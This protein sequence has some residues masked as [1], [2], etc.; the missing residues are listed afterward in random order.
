MNSYL[1]L[2]TNI[3]GTVRDVIDNKTIAISLVYI[4]LG[5][6]GSALSGLR[7]SG[8][9]NSISVWLVLLLAIVL[10][11]I[12]M[13]ICHFIYTGIIYL[14]GKL[15]K[16]T[17]GFFD[18]FKALSVSYIPYVLLIPIFLIWFLVD[19]SSVVATTD[20][21]TI[22]TSAIIGLIIV[23]IFGIYCLVIQ[24]IAVSEAHQFGIWR[25]IGTIF[26]PLILFTIIIFVI[27]AILFV[28]VLGFFVS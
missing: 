15:F 7:D 17:G 2:W 5:G 9:N 13:I 8:F 22:S 10:T 12:I 28:A 4:A 19:P 21:L 14:V 27:I 16:G 6:I 20:D 24:I 23:M 1:T 25:A 11:P 3:R 26:I 18:V